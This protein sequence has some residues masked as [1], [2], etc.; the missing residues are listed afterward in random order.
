M[1]ITLIV[2]QI[3]GKFM[4]CLGFQ[5]NTAAIGRQLPY[6]IHIDCYGGQQ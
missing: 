1:A 2:N 6:Y 4:S 3:N 5:P